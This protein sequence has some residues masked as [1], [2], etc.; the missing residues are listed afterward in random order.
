MVLISTILDRLENKGYLYTFYIFVFFILCFIS[1]SYFSYYHKIEPINPLTNY[2]PPSYITVYLGVGFKKPGFYDIP[3]N[4]TVADILS[5][6]PN[7]YPDYYNYDNISRR[8]KDGEKIDLKPL[9]ADYQYHINTGNYVSIV[10]YLNNATVYDLTSMP[11]IGYKTAEKILDYIK[12]NGPINNIDEL[13]NI[14]GVGKSTI[15]LLK[16]NI[17][18]LK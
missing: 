9:K 11:G 12:N 1:L 17:S 15:N 13:L 14:K 6:F 5:N 18:V 8:I 3:P 7:G 10:D 16:D 4:Y 2:I